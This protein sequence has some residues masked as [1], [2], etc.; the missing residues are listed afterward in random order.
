[1]F[2]ARHDLL[3]WYHPPEPGLARDLGVVLCAPNGYESLCVHWAL[4]ILAERL[5]AHGIPT[6][7]FDLAGTGDALGDD[8]DPGRVPAWLGS[9]RE[10][11]ELL[12]ARSLV[13]R[14]ALY[15]LRLG[16]TLATAVAAGSDSVQG[17]VLHAPCVTGRAYVRELKALALTGRGA[18]GPPEPTTNPNDVVMAG[19][20]ITEET[21]AALGRLELPKL[22]SIGAV[23]DVLILARDDMPADPKLPAHLTALGATVTAS[24]TDGYAAFMQD[25]L[26]AKLPTR[27]FDAIVAWA[28]ERSAAAPV[29]QPPELPP[30]RL[31]GETFTEEP[32]VFGNGALFGVLTTPKAPAAGNPVVVFT[33]TA[34]NHHIGTHRASVE[35]ARALA[36][37]GIGAF[38]FDVGG[39]GDSPA[40]PIDRPQNQ[41]YLKGTIPDV[42]T[43]I[44]LLVA[45]G[46]S[47]LVLTGL[48]SG[49]YLAFHALV[50]DPRVG[51]GVL[52]NTGRF[53]WKEGDSLDVARAQAV[54][55]TGTYF[56][57]ALKPE[58]WKR[59]ASG[60]VDVRLIAT[61]LGKRGVARAKSRASELVS[62]LLGPEFEPNE[63]PRGFLQLLQ[64]GAKVMLVYSKDDFSLAELVNHLGPGIRRLRGHPNAVLMGL[65]A[66][67][68]TLTTSAARRQL[69]DHLAQ[70]VSQLPTH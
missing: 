57:R 19:W 18:D 35:M 26:T 24:K 37:R 7:R 1:M 9:I 4:R 8:R 40:R 15:G 20:I 38:R 69:V 28:V 5:A 23:K 43:A 44:D 62:R 33:N 56:D 31:A 61:A 36:A 50:K 48:C 53:V 65:D 58:T 10:A 42:L 12:K 52:V 59:L 60:D 41:I 34:A 6:V 11:V 14:V 39:I 21:A 51:A 25:A 64:R 22:S 30:A 17:L 45:R 47:R 54:P 2:G 70:A 63:V 66:A 46:L 3:G 29:A 68:H 16:A 67:D 27:D 13:P 32:I 55:S 49:G